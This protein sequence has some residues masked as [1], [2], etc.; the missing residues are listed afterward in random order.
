M[1]QDNDVGMPILI[2][3]NKQD[4]DGAINVDKM[5]ELL[6][7]DEIFT[8]DV[9]YTIWSVIGISSKCSR[10]V[11][12]ALDL[13]HKRIVE[14]RLHTHPEPIRKQNIINKIFKDNKSE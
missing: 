2:I 10:D 12:L 6:K 11:P 14:R 9:P 13:L 4:L 1:N 7:L 3:G 8:A 5:T